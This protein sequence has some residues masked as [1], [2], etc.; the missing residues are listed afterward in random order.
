MTPFSLHII[1]LGS[2]YPANYG[3]AIDMYFK[4][5]ALHD[6]GAQIQLYAFGDPPS[7]MQPLR[8]LCKSVHFYP[9]SPWRGAIKMLFGIPYI[10]G[11]RPIKGVV[12]QMIAEIGTSNS[13]NAVL[14]EGLHVGEALAQLQALG[15]PVLLRMHN[16]EAKY[17]EALSHVERRFWKRLYLRLET[18]LLKKYQAEI[19]QKAKLIAAISQSETNYFKTETEAQVEWIPPFFESSSAPV[20]PKN[21]P[22]ALYHGNLR[23]AEN[24]EAVRLLIKAGIQDLT[25]AGQGAPQELIREMQSSGITYLPASGA[26][27]ESLVSTAQVHV[28]PTLQATGVKLKLLHAIHTKAPVV[29]N[30]AMV[31]G[32]GL[33][34]CVTIVED[35]GGNWQ[36]AIEAA[37]PKDCGAL[38]QYDTKVL[39]QKLIDMLKS[40]RVI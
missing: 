27:M 9:K 7:D 39:A 40:P 19:L 11:C 28:L 21:G 34:D 1:A 15:F 37:K 31:E 14:L 35:F 5:K 8:N 36:A 20:F 10:V 17:Y 16:N 32:T 4:I 6:L 29:C 23:V 12:T 30:R 26:E 24:Q 33:S 13:Q 25:V 18:R 38:S 2:P 3:G 22:K